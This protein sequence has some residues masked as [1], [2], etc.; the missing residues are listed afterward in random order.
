MAPAKNVL[1][2]EVVSLKRETFGSGHSP[3]PA[4]G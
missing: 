2:K 3:E 4:K 1:A